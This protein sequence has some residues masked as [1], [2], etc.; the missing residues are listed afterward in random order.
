MSE[1][2]SATTE[3]ETINRFQSAAEIQ[4][5]IWA[6]QREFQAKKSEIKAKKTQ[7]ELVIDLFRQ[8]LRQDLRRKRTELR[9]EF[10]RWNSENGLRPLRKRL[11]HLKELMFAHHRNLLR[12]WFT[13]SRALHPIPA[14]W[15]SESDGDRIGPSTLERYNHLSRRRTANLSFRQG[16]V[17]PAHFVI[18]L[19]LDIVPPYVDYEP[20]TAD[21]A[22]EVRE[23]LYPKLSSA[24]QPVQG[25]GVW[26][27]TVANL[28]FSD[29]PQ[30]PIP[31][32]A[33]EPTRQ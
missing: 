27:R 25:E 20:I 30:F 17:N 4:D 21:E 24:W 2:T 3:S 29:G 26:V 1:S 10:A 8:V 11:S 18:H 7:I 9:A 28:L 19:V 31:V 32:P 6:T 13:N 5:V 23:S 15:V 12:Q 22:T 16:S 33:T 14:G